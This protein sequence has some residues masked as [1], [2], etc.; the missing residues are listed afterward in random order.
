MN[1][2]RRE[3]LDK[4]R[5]ELENLWLTVDNLRIEEEE[6]HDNMPESLQGGEKGKQSQTAIDALYEAVGS[7]GNAINSIEEATGA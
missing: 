1:K 5:V 2:A 4:V 6:Y 3:A 7:I